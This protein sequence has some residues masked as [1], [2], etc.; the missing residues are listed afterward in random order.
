MQPFLQLGCVP[1]YSYVKSVQC[2]ERNLILCKMC[3]V[4]Q[5]LPIESAKPL[6]NVAFQGK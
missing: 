4:E 5:T 2:S 3:Y 1:R 6:E